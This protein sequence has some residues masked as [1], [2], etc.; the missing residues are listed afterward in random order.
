MELN[1]ELAEFV[2]VFVGDGCLSRYKRSDRI[3]NIEEIQFT[4]SWS[5]DSQ[6]YL[7]IIQPIIKRNFNVDGGITHRKDDDTVRYRITNREV[8]SFLKNLDF[9]FGPKATKV[10]IPNRILNN[11]SLHESFLRGFFNT[12]G[13]I[14]KRYS[15]QYKNHAKFYQ[16]YKVIQFKSASKELMSQIYF[17]L[18]QLGFKPNRVIKTKD[19]WV[20]R[21]TFQKEVNNFGEEIITNHKYH[22]D[23][24]LS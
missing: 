15:K 2:G 3:G 6:Y 1:K 9:S 12:D 18:D 19:C 10:K 17:I 7:E 8:I 22:R 23:R 24:F 14:Y 5:K 11:S 4:G 21:I 20:C 16:N 13:T